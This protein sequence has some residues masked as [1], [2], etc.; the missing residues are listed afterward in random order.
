MNLK[1][2]Y[3]MPS[4]NEKRSTMRKVAAVVMIL[5]AGFAVSATAQ[6]DFPSK[7]IQLIIGYPP[8]GGTD[9]LSRVLAHEARNL[10]SRDA[11]V[12]NKPGGSG[13]LAVTSVAAAQPDGYTLGVTPNSSLTT[14]HFVQNVAPDLLER[15]TAL[16]A[17]GRLKGAL[18]TRSDNPMRSVKDLIEYARRNPGK[19]SIGVPGSGSKPSLVFQALGVHEKV[20]LNVVPF[21][22]EAPA[23]TALLGAHV[24]AVAISSSTWERQF[25]AGTVRMIAST[26]D[27]RL[28]IDMNV[29]TLI[30]QG[31]PQSAS[32]IFYLYGPKGLPPAVAKRLIEAFS[33][34]TRTPAYHDMAAKNAIEIGEPISGE[35]LERF[36]FED[37]A[38]TGTMVEKLNI[39]KS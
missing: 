24:T 37:R 7:P 13:T 10:L 35:V 34:A 19:V 27:K 32:S 18:L 21:A 33:A 9:I 2:D 4:G 39:K 5:L 26:D 29:P 23:L 22:G 20:E 1:G 6:T 8:G 11:I 15:T 12:V 16:V 17:V 30:E 3:H 28:K 14:A 38:K 31:F 25:A 36:L